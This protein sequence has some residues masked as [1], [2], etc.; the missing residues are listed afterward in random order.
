[1]NPYEAGFD[2]GERAAFYDRQRP[3]T[4]GRT[5]GPTQTT[6]EYDRGWWDGYT[7][8]HEWWGW[9]NFQPAI[10]SETT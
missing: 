3:V 10:E 6:S 1:M 5:G 2:A 4:A 7:P 8:R 9:R